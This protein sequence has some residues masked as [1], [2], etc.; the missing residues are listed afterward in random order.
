LI[1]A[2]AIRGPAPDDVSTV[3]AATETGGFSIDQAPDKL[4]NQ[5]G[6]NRLRHA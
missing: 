5:E 4:T 3:P 2:Q 6:S 1:Q